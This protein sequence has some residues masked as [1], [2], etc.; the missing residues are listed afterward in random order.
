[1]RDPK[2]N[3]SFSKVALDNRDGEEFI[4]RESDDLV[5]EFNCKATSG[6]TMRKVCGVT[7]RKVC[8][9][10]MRKVCGVTMRNIYSPTVPNLGIHF[11]SQAV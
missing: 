7:M 9:V 5:F 6:V 4:L 2:R 10:T 11:N 8:G 1:M 3:R